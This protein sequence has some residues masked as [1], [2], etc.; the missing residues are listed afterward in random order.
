MDNGLKDSI[1][2][3]ADNRFAKGKIDL[4]LY[5]ALIL[6]ASCMP[7]GINRILK[8]TLARLSEGFS[9]IVEASLHCALSIFVIGPLM[10]GLVR[11]ILDLR[12]GDSAKNCVFYAFD[13]SRY[14]RVVRAVAL[15][16]IIGSVPELL[17]CISGFIGLD[18][19]KWIVFMTSL[20]IA[21]VTVF[22]LTFVYQ[23]IAEDID[24]S[25]TDACLK[26]IKL[27]TGKKKA[28][29]DLI[30]SYWLPILIVI[31]TV[32]LGLIYAAPLML[33]AVTCYYERL[34]VEAA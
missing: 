31:V 20:G 16:G 2:A 21:F 32:G 23:I 15:Y 6:I 33:C 30:L 7:I 4:M 24:I 11:G 28:L 29:F 10:V 26:S 18:I 5:Y 14:M 9:G 34:R 27:M 12:N 17:D 1:R 3:E 8:L 19:M 13:D 25:P 22:M